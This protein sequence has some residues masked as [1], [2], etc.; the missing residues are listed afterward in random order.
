M[1]T[2]HFVCCASLRLDSDFANVCCSAGPGARGGQAV[3]RVRQQRRV[4]RRAARR[5]R[6]VGAT[7]ARGAP[8]AVKGASHNRS[9]PRWFEGYCAPQRPW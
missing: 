6:V 7:A 1:S 5:R 2:V 4:G 3:A 9:A 8:L